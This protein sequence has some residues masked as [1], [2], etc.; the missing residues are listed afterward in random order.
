MAKR[1]TDRQ[2]NA[3]RFCENILGVKYS[4]GIDDSVAVDKFLDKYL[5]K[6]D[7][8]YH[9]RLESKAERLMNFY[10]AYGSILTK[11]KTKRG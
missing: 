5:S 9:K 2:K 7:E 11:R 8:V 1:V 6:A 3:V 4:G 10:S